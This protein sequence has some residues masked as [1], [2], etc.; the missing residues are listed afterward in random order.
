[1][2]FIKK[3]NFKVTSKKLVIFSVL[4]ILCICL[5]NSLKVEN[6]KKDKPLERKVS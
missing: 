5:S 3:R 6:N 2:K 1:M 4:S